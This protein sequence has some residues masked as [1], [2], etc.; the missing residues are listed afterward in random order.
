MRDIPLLLFGPTLSLI[1]F[2]ALPAVVLGVVYGLLT[3]MQ[4][5]KLQS[6][7]YTDQ[8]RL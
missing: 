3:G 7:K 1:L 6:I 5:E 4:L 2:G 8:H